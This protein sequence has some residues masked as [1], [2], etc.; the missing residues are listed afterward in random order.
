[1]NTTESLG[2][3]IRAHRRARGLTQAELAEKSGRSIDAISQIERGLNVP[4]VETLVAVAE[5]LDVPLGVMI[6]TAHN[7][8]PQRRRQQ[9]SAAVAAL[10]ALTDEQLD[11][12]VKQIEAFK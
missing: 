6:D 3:M 8:W 7:S 5:A 10:S 1:M 11:I 2:K 9:F 4:S 12:A